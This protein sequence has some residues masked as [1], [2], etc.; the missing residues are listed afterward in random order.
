MAAGGALFRMPSLDRERRASL[1]AE[2]RAFWAVML[3]LAVSLSIVSGTRQ[4]PS[5][6]V[7]SAASG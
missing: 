2:E 3:S 6:H 7:Q 5:L 4:R 1:D